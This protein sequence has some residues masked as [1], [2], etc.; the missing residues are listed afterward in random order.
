MI[1]I[2]KKNEVL[3]QL[4][5]SRKLKKSIGLVPTMG[6]LHKGHL[7]LIKKAVLENDI[8]WVSIFINPTQF[9]RSSDLENYPRNLQEDLSLLERYSKKVRVFSPSVNEIYGKNMSVNAY[10]FDLLDKKLEGKYR[11]NH[12]NGVATIVSKLLNL[13]EPRDVYFGEKDFQQ[14]LII[15]KL[16]I[17]EKLK[18]NLKICPTVRERNGLAL[19]SRNMLLSAQEKK[20]ASI[21]Y[22]SLIFI[23]TNFRNKPQHHLIK[24]VKNSIEK[25]KNFKVQYL[26]ICDNESLYH[27]DYKN[28]N[29][30]RAFICVEV[31]DVRL[32]D[33]ILLN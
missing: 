25:I 16:I 26:E 1:S 32:I 10:D 11:K 19:S 27:Y 29:I 8:V 30:C 17:I 2:S 21:I 31:N 22:E 18:V 4:K 13:F 5:S 9:N 6:S 15:K 28:D 23:K 24:K 20:M 33:N 12:F 7:S 14:V 3:N